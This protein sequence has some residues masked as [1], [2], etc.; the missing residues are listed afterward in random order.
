MN[1]KH[2]IIEE[3]RRAREAI[4]AGY[5]YDIRACAKA[6]NAEAKASGRKLIT[7]IVKARPNARFPGRTSRQHRE[8]V[9]A[10]L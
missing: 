5:D 3:V 7:R 2:D 9:L 10:A 8:A 4:L 1:T 6:L